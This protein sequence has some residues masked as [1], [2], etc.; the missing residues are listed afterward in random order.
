M[1]SDVTIDGL[2][3]VIRALGKFSP[4]A[5]KELRYRA[6]IIATQYMMPAYKNAA[7]GVPIWGG[8]LANSIRVKKDR[9]PSLSIGYQRKA[10]SGGASSIML[11]Y[12]TYSGQ[13]RESF[14]PF[15]ETA[16]IKKAG[17]AYKGK[18]M[19][20]WTRAIEHLVDLWNRGN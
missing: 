20:E 19:D 17:P 1:A 5:N 15:A 9:T 16:W 6:G 12:P 8:V 18:A 11:R 4:Q 10:L 13:R 2:N 3:A 7:R 14:A